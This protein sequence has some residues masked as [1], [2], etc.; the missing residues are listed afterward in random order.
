MSG[1][2]TTFSPRTVLVEFDKNADMKLDEKELADLAST[3]K[4]IRIGEYDYFQ[5]VTHRWQE[6]CH[7]RAWQIC[8]PISRTINC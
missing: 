1:A 7:D 3:I 2:L 5:A 4:P 8:W 6:Y